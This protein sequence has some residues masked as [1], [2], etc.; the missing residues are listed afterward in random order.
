[1][2]KRPRSYSQAPYSEGKGFVFVGDVKRPIQDVVDFINNTLRREGFAKAIGNRDAVTEFKQCDNIKRWRLQTET[3]DLAEQICYL[4][5]IYFEDVILHIRHDRHSR[6]PRFSCWNEYHWHK[7]HRNCP[8]VDMQ[9]FATCRKDIQGDRLALGLVKRMK[10]FGLAK[11]DPEVAAIRAWRAISP[12][13]F[14]LEMLSSEKASHLCYLNLIRIEN[15]QVLLERPKYWHGPE[16][17]FKSFYDYL[18]AKT[19]QAKSKGREQQKQGKQRRAKKKIPKVQEVIEIVDSDDDETDNYAQQVRENNRLKAD[20]K[21]RKENARL[22]TV[23]AKLLRSNCSKMKLNKNLKKEIIA[24]TNRVARKDR[25]LSDLRKTETELVEMLVV[26]EQQVLD[27]HRDWQKQESML[28][29]KNEEVEI[30]NE[31]IQG[32]QHHLHNVTDSVEE[33]KRERKKMEDVLIQC[34]ERTK[35]IVSV[36]IQDTS[37]LFDV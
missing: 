11:G 19:Q 22:K 26:K 28:N 15:T 33:E 21:V 36:K 20:L 6:P 29:E 30:L 17:E 14:I 4:N 8:T 2:P 9:V 13:T 5:K 3:L 35:K 1:M 18:K 32:L 27:I 10:D 37:T 24:L 16:P 7:Y 12:R 34:E 23:Y 25:R 31:E